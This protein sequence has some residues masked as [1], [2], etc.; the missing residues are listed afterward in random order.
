MRMNDSIRPT[1]FPELGYR[2]DGPG[3][4]RFVDTETGATIGPFYRTKAELLG[5]LHRFAAD[6]GLS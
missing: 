6:Y 3:L 1:R 2:N 5:D 4:W